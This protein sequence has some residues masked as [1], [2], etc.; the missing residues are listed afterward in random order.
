MKEQQTMKG[1]LQMRLPLWN[2]RKEKFA[3]H[4]V[5]TAAYYF[6]LMLL[7]YLSSKADIG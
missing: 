7:I 4:K 6:F 5:N 2:Y 1:A 3:R